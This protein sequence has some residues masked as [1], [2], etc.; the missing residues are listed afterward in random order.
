MTRGGFSDLMFAGLN[1]AYLL[2]FNA[3]PE[4]YTKYLNI[5]GSTKRQEEDA[6]TAGF[7][8]VPEKDEGAQPY[9]DIMAYINKLQYLHKTYVMGYEVTEECFEDEL[10]G[11]M[12]KGSQA[13]ATAVK[14]TVDTL[15]AAVLNN[16]FSGSYVGVDG[17]S[18]CNTAHPAEKTG[19]NVANR[20]STDLDF[21][22]T[23]LNSALETWEEWTN[24]N[25]LPLMIMPKYVVSGPRQRKIITEVL[26]ST[27][28]PFTADNEINAVREWELEKMILHYLT[29]TDAWWILSRP[30]DH[31]MKWFWRVRPTFRNYDDPDTGNARFLTRFRASSGF[32]HW[33]GVYGSSGG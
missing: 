14:Q 18:L 29:D 10:Y 17:V 11:I 2:A 5:E 3:Y 1:E 27:Q 31:F 7:G 6:V 23:A 13:L 25:D 28:R 15:A 30:A 22:A 26:G 9:F 16:A 12:R 21:S 24:D 20:P 32:T 33:W 8:L 19:T 4:E